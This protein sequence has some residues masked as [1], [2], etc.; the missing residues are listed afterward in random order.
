[1]VALRKIIRFFRRCASWHLSP[2]V[3]TV[4]LAFT[5]TVNP[6][7][8]GAQQPLQ[9][10]AKIVSDAA[11]LLCYDRAVVGNAL[12][13]TTIQPEVTS[14][15]ANPAPSFFPGN[16]PI[17][18]TTQ[19]RVAAGYGFGVGDHTGTFKILGGSVHLE[20]AIGSSGAI[21]SGQVWVDGWIGQDWSLGMEYFRLRHRAHANA[22][23]P[24]G[25]S[26]L[27]DPTQ[28]YASATLATDI[29][30]VNLAYRPMEGPIRPFVGIG[31]GIG[32]GSGALDFGF[33]NPFLGSV[34][35]S[36]NKGTILAGVQA[37]SGVEFDLGKYAYL[38]LMPRIVWIDG[39]PVGVDQRYLDLSFTGL[40]GLR[41]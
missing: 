31:L 7:P 11:R 24:R 37:F 33:S 4:I 16:V 8:A 6:T 2:Y 5:A 17:K 36:A 41:F 21:A 13:G 18:R 9:A 15:P 22:A 34:R 40:V 32:Y 28:L 14:I 26:I 25:I 38:A 1:M 29:G 10:C 30:F 12:I 39:H 20:S 27:T 3:L 35:A 19:Y 23:Y